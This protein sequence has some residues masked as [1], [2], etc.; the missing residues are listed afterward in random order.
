MDIKIEIVLNTPNI[1][2][3]LYCL[4]RL[5]RSMLYM[6]KFRKEWYI[7][8][9]ITGKI[10]N[11]NI[12]AKD[13]ILSSILSKKKKLSFR[14]VLKKN[15]VIILL[16]LLSIL[17]FVFI[18]KQFDFI[19]LIFVVFAFIFICL[20]VFL[21]KEIELLDETLIGSAIWNFYNFAV[22][23]FLSQISFGA[24]KNSKNTETYEKIK[25]FLD[26]SYYN[27]NVLYEFFSKHY[28]YIKSNPLINI[29]NDT[30]DKWIPLIKTSQQ[31]NEFIKEL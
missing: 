14:S 5:T 16:F 1:C 31:T 29:Y 2:I 24:L 11:P 3:I 12:N 28:D 30:T 13:I 20:Y 4:Y 25:G 19:N 17:Y 26:D 15:K 8:S 6:A 22:V 23:N 7:G 10:T 21:N 27:C 9:L 18:V